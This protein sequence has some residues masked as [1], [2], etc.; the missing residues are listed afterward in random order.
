LGKFSGKPGEKFV[1][2]FPNGEVL[3]AEVASNQMGIVVFIIDEGAKSLMAGRSAMI[4]EN[5]E[6]GVDWKAYPIISSDS[7]SLQQDQEQ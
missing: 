5:N 1:V 3:D 6:F 4:E 7:P 2:E